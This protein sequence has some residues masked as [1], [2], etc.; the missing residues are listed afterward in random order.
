MFPD[1]YSHLDDE[2][3]YIERLLRIYSHQWQVIQSEEGLEHLGG[4]DGLTGG[5]GRWQVMIVLSA[6]ELQARLAPALLCHDYIGG[7]MGL[8]KESF[9]EKVILSWVLRHD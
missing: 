8:F 6:V 4:A 5:R 9:K 7:E 2:S 3:I 1:Y